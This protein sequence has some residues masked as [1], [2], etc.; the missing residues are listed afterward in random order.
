MLDHFDA[1]RIGLTATPLVGDCPR[2]GTRTTRP[3]C[4][5]RSSSSRSSA[6]TFRYTLKEAVEAGYLVPYRIYRAQT[7][8]TA[9]TGGFEVKREEID[10]EALDGDTRA[11]LEELFGGGNTINVDPA[12][13]ERRFTVPERNRAMVREFR[14]VLEKGYTGSD[15]VRRAPAT[16]ARRSCSR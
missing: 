1:V 2:I 16:G 14:E 3:R 11:E 4:A 8:K 5:T 6:P 12:A 7:V 9:A 13:L 15:G 10:W